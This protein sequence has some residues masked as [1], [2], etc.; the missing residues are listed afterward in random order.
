M[1]DK[2]P[3]EGRGGAK[4]EIRQRCS[5]PSLA[6]FILPPSLHTVVFVSV[7]CADVDALIYIT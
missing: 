2:K 4:A 3:G 5:D 6:P 1:C 7:C